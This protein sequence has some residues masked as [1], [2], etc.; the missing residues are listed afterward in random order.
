M[1]K[2]ILKLFGKFRPN[3]KKSLIIALAAI[4]IIIMVII[5]TIEA[6]GFWGRN[7]SSVD[8]GNSTIAW[9]TESSSEYESTETSSMV[10]VIETVSEIKNETLPSVTSAA[11]VVVTNSPGDPQ[12]QD[13][14]NSAGN[15]AVVNASDLKTV[16]VNNASN[17]IDVS[18][19][20]GD[21]DWKAVAA[22]GL[23][24]AIIRVG[25]RGTDDAKIHVDSYAQGN[26]EE[27]IAAGIKVGAYFA[28]TAITEAEVLEEAKWTVNFIS[29]YTINYP[30][31]YDC[32]GFSVSGSRMNGITNAIRT[33]YAMK[34]LNYVQSQNY[35]GMLYASAS[36]LQK[37]WDTSRISASYKIWVAQYPNTPYPTTAQTSYSGTHA[38]WQYTDK[39]VVIGIR[40]P[41]CINVAYF[42]NDNT[43][44]PKDTTPAVVNYTEVM[45]LVTSLSTTNIRNTASTSGNIVSTI[46]NGIYYTRTGVGDNGWSRILYGDNQTGYAFTEYLTT[47][48][49]MTFVSVNDQVTANDVVNL[50]RLPST[51]YGE[52]Y[53]TLSSTQYLTRTGINEATGWSRLTYSDGTT[54]YAVS[55]K[56]N[57]QRQ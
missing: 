38:M 17:G 40:N 21:I 37:F 47:G 13:G 30:V 54:V 29:K 20:T 18:S 31:A 7:N 14:N 42:K 55:N 46:N 19:W 41:V 25:Y 6:E 50:R 5:I 3:N 34:F 10:A 44:V 53:A 24:F 16:E 32:E 2:K 33:D 35:E 15:G 28:S 9:T 52:V 26:L 48:T 8:A 23:K 57:T 1:K 4:A 12:S 49:T 36:D 56:I 27:A 22:T 43:V 11:E 51:T 39:G 45:E